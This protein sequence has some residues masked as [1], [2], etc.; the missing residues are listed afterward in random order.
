AVS[1]RT[2]LSELG[3]DS[4]M[5]VELR[6]RLSS[7]L[8]LKRALPATLVFDY[9]TVGAIA[10]YLAQETLGLQKPQA[11]PEP[12]VREAAVNEGSMLDMLSALENLS[13]D[14]I[15]LQLSEK[16]KDR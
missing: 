10:T 2:P 11:T 15:D 13:D 5:A 14:E 4:L 12:P 9:P 7:G 1:E 6:N 16:T 3:L 8:G